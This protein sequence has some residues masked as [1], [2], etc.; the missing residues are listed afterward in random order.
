MKSGCTALLRR[1]LASRCG[2][3]AALY[4]T[5]RFWSLP[6]PELERQAVITG[7]RHLAAE[8]QGSTMPGCD[9]SYGRMPRQRRVCCDC[10]GTKTWTGE[11]QISRAKSAARLFF[12]W[13]PQ[14]WLC[15]FWFPW[16]TRQKVP[17]SNA[18]GRLRMWSLEP[19]R[20][21]CIISSIAQVTASKLSVLRTVL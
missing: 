11:V 19:W 3:G 16:T 1:G 9:S 13:F 21:L 5:G 10:E 8:H 18:N 14:S 4:R 17:T 7:P 20:R 2:E 6:V 15:W 12:F